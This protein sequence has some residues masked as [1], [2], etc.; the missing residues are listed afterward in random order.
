MTRSDKAKLDQLQP[1]NYVR[2]LF[3][4][5]V[6]VSSLLVFQVQP[7]IAK[8]VLPWFG[9][10]PAVWTVCLLFFQ[11]GLFLG[12]AYAMLT[13]RHLPPRWQ[14]SL[15]IVLMALVLL[16]LPITPDAGWKP[17]AGGDPT[18]RLLFL[19]CVSVGL[20]YL[21]LSSTGPLLL[22]WFARIQPQV[23]PYPLYSVSNLG[24]M[25]GLLS[26]PFLVE[27]LLAAD[28]QTQTWSW[29]FW[30]FAAGC[31]ACGLIL[32]RTDS[33]KNL[34]S[35]GDATTNRAKAIDSKL[36][37]GPVATWFFLAMI[38]SVMLLATTNMVC[39]DVAVVPFLWVLPLTL[40][41]LT[42]ILCFH[43]LRWCSR[44]VWT[45][46]WILLAALTVHVLA[47]G[48][49]VTTSYP[50]PVQIGVLFGLLF[51]T[52]MVCHGELVR[53]KPHPEY[54]TAFYLTMAG[55]G[56]AGGVFVGL[57]APQVFPTNV[58][59]SIGMIGCA[60]LMSVVFFRDPNSWL[61]GGRPRWAWTGLL[62]GIAA[63]TWLQV[64]QFQQ[65]VGGVEEI[66]RNFFGVLQVRLMPASDPENGYAC[67]LIHGRTMHGLQLLDES[68]SR[69]PTAYY[70]SESGIGQVLAE[71][72]NPPRRVGVVGLG[73]GTVAAYA[74]PEDTYRFYEINPAVIDVAQRFFGYLPECQGSLELIEGD[75]RIML[76][77]EPPQHFDVLAL[78]AF[79]SDSIPVHLLTREAFSIYLRHLQEDGIL[80]VHISNV[81]VDLRPVVAG[82][83]RHFGLAL[84]TIESPA[85]SRRETRRAIWALLARNGEALARAGVDRS[86]GL[87]PPE[88]LLNWTDQQNSVFQTLRVWSEDDAK[89]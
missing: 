69:W 55:G 8:Y 52:G 40:Y 42:F 61:R 9:G 79:S 83:A 20:P 82:H 65:V 66:H 16:L 23:S 56:A 80:A 53:T 48:L 24:S 64:S 4:A 77:Q 62:V 15:H 37:F 14:A 13:T 32:W 30:L 57:V 54:L 25:L 18:W 74:R 1:A 87:P 17:D 5:T 6:F 49:G 59:V 26:Y 7:L 60:L 12:Y 44:R 51:C 45:V 88:R 72:S 34:K 43:D 21:V 3:A 38:P 58:E 70:G 71:R 89:L 78:D 11:V 81:H 75:A 31:S 22:A 10:T 27:P 19:L 36:R 85:D 2:G 28:R 39:T 67:Q 68:K 33:S 84:A 63:L 41:L 47:R 86:K 50:I 73:I 35:M 76:E 46:A 29:G